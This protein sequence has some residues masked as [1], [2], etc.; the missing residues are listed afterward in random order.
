M[1]A[2]ESLKAVRRKYEENFRRLINASVGGRRRE[3]SKLAREEKRLNELCVKLQ[4]K[5]GVHVYVE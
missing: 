2:E 3:H 5:L 4:K 1:F